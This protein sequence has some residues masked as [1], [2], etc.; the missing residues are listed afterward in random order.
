MQIVARHMNSLKIPYAFL[1]ASVL[2]LLV[3]NP[4][5]LDIRPTMDIDLTIQIA[6]LV[7]FYQ[8]EERLRHIGFRNDTRDEAPICRW[9]IEAVT[10]DII[11]TEAAVLGMTSEWFP[12][13]VEHAIVIEL[14]N[15]IRVP[16]ITR[17]FFL[18]TK[19]TAYR[20]RGAKDPYLSKDLEDIV[21]LLNGCE[22]TAAILANAPLTLRNFVA[23]QL[24]THLENQEFTDA[25]AG[26]FRTDSTSRQRAAIILERFR[27]LATTE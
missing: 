25:V 20:D 6:T 8:L 17:P 24:A 22:D 27:A 15:D 5:I 23:L 13:V 26:C 21:T 11:P 16:I 14:G 7:D 1:G 9:I 10:V 12:E 2:P 4:D 18:A 19:L 3:D